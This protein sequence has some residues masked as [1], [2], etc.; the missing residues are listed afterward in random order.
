MAVG[1]LDMTFFFLILQPH[2]HYSSFVTTKTGI[3]V[4]SSHIVLGLL[5]VPD[6]DEDSSRASHFFSIFCS[7]TFQCAWI[8]DWT[9]DNYHCDCSRCGCGCNFYHPQA[10]STTFFNKTKSVL[11]RVCNVH[12]SS[13]NIS[14]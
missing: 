14:F 4:T 13:R 2:Y 9:D 7:F 3:G 8:G 5:A 1:V 6:A 11:G 10:V 12:R